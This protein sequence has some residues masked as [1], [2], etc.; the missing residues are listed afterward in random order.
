MWVRGILPCLIPLS[1][2]GLEKRY[3]LDMNGLE[4]RY[5]EEQKKSH[6]D[7][8]ALATGSEKE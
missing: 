1:L 6:P 5:F 8:F 4:K 7:R 2:L 3:S